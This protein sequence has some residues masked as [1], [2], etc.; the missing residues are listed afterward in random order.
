LW[1]KI[2]ANT[3]CILVVSFAV[4]PF[5]GSK[6]DLSIQVARFSGAAVGV[7]KLSLRIDVQVV[8]SLND[9][10]LVPPIT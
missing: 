7:A 4:L 1:Q 3:I 6:V 10:E 2:A 8:K 9:S 5:F